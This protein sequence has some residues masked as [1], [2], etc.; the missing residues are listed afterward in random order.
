MLRTC[1]RQVA[2]V[3]LEGQT[4]G[5]APGRLQANLVILP[6]AH[7][8]DF[9]RYCQRNS[10]SCPLVGVTET[11]G[12][13][14]RTLGTDIN[15]RTD[16][17]GYNTY[18]NGVLVENLT[19]IRD[20]W[21]G[22]FVAFALGCSFTFERALLEAGIDLGHIETNRTVPMYR[23]TIETRAA[24]PFAGGMVVSMRMI[25]DDRVDDAA[26]ISKRDPWAHGGPVHIGDPSLIGIDGLGAPDRGD[27][28]SMRA[29]TT[30]VF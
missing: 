29:G 17:P 15:V 20:L 16:F 13:L 8:L 14:L 5:L 10:K 22:N 12:P 26:H 30:P 7:A 11:G 18:R 21:Q 6:E 24:R 1:A 19:D 28:P 27:P 2:T 9:M 25:A 4:A 3:S 23:T